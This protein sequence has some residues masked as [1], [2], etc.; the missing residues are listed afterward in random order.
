MTE[1]ALEIRHGCAAVVFENEKDLTYCDVSPL[2]RV[3]ERQAQWE[4]TLQEKTERAL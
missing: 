3:A 1:L 2:L 4:G